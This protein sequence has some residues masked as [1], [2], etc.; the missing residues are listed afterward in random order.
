[1]KIAIIIHELENQGGGERQCL[2]LAEA[3]IRRGHLVTVFTSV[4]KANCYPE[5]CSNLNIKVIGRGP[6]RYLRKPFVLRGYLDMLRLSASV[7]EQ[8][9]IWNPHH[10]PAQWAAV[11]LKRKLGGSVVWM[12]NDVPDFYQK[13]RQL[14]SLST[15]LQAPLRWSYFLIDRLQNRKVDLTLFLSQWAE[16]EFRAIYT[17][18]TY[19]VRSGSDPDRFRPGG[20]RDKIRNRF[21]YK[22]VDFVLLWLGI[23][24]PHRRLEDAIS[25]IALLNARGIDVKLLLAGSTTSY[26]DYCKSLKELV[27]KMG[28]KS[29]VTFAD[30]VADSEIC[31]FYAACDAFVFP[32]ERQTWG[33]VIF[34]AMA[35]GCPVLVSRGAAVHE[36]LTDNENAL[37]Y[38]PRNPGLLA[39][40][41]E[42]LLTH[43]GTR[44]RIAQNGQELA[45][46]KYTWQRF[47]DQIVDACEHVMNAKQ[48]D[49]ALD[50]SNSRRSTTAGV[51]SA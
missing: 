25:A 23:F 19:V 29:Q 32:N 4:Y 38:P 8:Y 10:W 15:A 1:M 41:I 46:T 48:P 47:A 7:H 30:R 27:S 14:K 33:L 45:R 44:R 51:S 37:L 42:L 16:R 3:L 18:R 26:P 17:G 36:V 28:V 40:K 49:R 6:L 9:D 35:C 34:E 2:A 24:M 31:D 50:P 20:D 21:G 13:A 43:P 11:R 22:S 5:I 39:Q 12:C